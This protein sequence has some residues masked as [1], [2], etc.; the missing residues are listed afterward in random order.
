MAKNRHRTPATNREPYTAR[1]DRCGFVVR[2]AESSRRGTCKMRPE[3]SSRI[4][5][6]VAVCSALAFVVRAEAQWKLVESVSSPKPVPIQGNGSHAIATEHPELSGEIHFSDKLLDVHFKLFRDGRFQW[7]VPAPSTEIFIPAE[8]DLVIMVLNR[9]DEL[10]IM[11]D[12]VSHPQGFIA[13]DARGREVA[14]AENVGAIGQFHLLPDGRLLYI[15]DDHLELRDF[16]D[17]GRLVWKTDLPS[18]TL[19][20]V[21]DEYVIT[22]YSDLDT[23]QHTSTLYDIRA[24][25]QLASFGSPLDTRSA[26]FAVSSDHQYAF[27][28]TTFATQP[29]TFA[30]EAYRIGTWDTP[31]A[32]ISNFTGGPFAAD[33]RGDYFAVGYTAYI[34]WPPSREESRLQSHL[35]IYHLPS[36]A[37]TF[38]YAFGPSQTIEWNR[39]YVTFDENEDVM[40]RHNSEVFR[41]SRVD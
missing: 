11:V 37:T 4:V 20:V 27:L 19:R 17:R 40:I 12:R 23:R 39:S 29:P 9:P 28:R 22:G 21:R 36:N 41:F 32:T 38:E 3:W 18:H 25:E 16:A 10:P 6:M 1:I 7:Q 14:L 30:V 33:L 5:A 31:F 2:R 35:R 13:Y 26:L 34:A 8:A 24:G 15:A